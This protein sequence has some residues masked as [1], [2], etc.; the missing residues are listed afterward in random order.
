MAVYKRK[1]NRKDSKKSESW[2]V[3]VR[4][5]DG[6]KLKRTIGKV[7]VVTKA[8]ARQEEQR[9]LKDITLGK[10]GAVTQKSPILREFAVEYI[11]HARDVKGKRTWK[12]DEQL[13]K[14][15]LKLFGNKRLSEVSTKDIEDFKLM[16]LKEVKPATVNRAL[17]VL[18]T[19]FNTAKK[20]NQYYGENP[21]SIV[22]LLHEDSFEERILSFEEQRELL[23]QSIPY[24]RPI[25][26]TALNT[27]MRRNEILNLKW[28]D[29]DLDKGY[30]VVDQTN[31]KS[32]KE[33]QICLNEDVRKVFVELKLRSAGS[34]YVFIDDK[35]NK[36]NSIRTAFEAACR[37]ANLKGLRFHDLRH[38]TAT[39]MVECGANIVAVS[40][41]LG[42]SDIKTTMRYTH[43]DESMKEAVHILSKLN[44]EAT[45]LATNANS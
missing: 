37:R 17:S 38:T 12:N 43:P 19:L 29:V 4:L 9:L 3:E 18:R 26:I 20:W 22:G 7:G 42:H 24:L 1:I 45:N 33:R 14:P 39:R 15:I 11:A 40:R 8:V 23:E 30:L 25:I 31:S 34:D 41:I 6:K 32:K 2:V 5:P 44:K 35:G 28:S 36:I 13:L 16:R 27:A 10:L 21:V